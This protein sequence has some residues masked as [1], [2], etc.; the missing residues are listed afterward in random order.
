[1]VAVALAP[2]YHEGGDAFALTLGGVLHRLER[3]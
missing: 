2:T 3:G 1:V